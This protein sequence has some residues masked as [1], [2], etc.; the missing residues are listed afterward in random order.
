LSFEQDSL[1]DLADDAILDDM[2]ENNGKP[3]LAIEL[4]EINNSIED[5]DTR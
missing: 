3:S 4:G 1:F 5:S 2:A